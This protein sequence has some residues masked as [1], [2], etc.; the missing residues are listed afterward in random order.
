MFTRLATFNGTTIDNY[1]TGASVT[2]FTRSKKS[3][4]LRNII[5][6]NTVRK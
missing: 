2:N 6:M 5:L 1:A 4:K 3:L